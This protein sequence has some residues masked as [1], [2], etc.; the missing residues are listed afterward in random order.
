MNKDHGKSRGETVW[1]AFVKTFEVG[2]EGNG[3]D[4]QGM[5]HASGRSGLVL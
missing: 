1:E 3:R 2:S 4:V 5:K